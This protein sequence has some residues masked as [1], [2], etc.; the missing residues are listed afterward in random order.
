M[1]TEL[2]KEVKFSFAFACSHGD[3]DSFVY[4]YPKATLLNHRSRQNIFKT[5]QELLLYHSSL[6]KERANKEWEELDLTFY[7]M[8]RNIYPKE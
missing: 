1:T 5:F 3:F 6:Y 8:K 7:S 2:G 4:T